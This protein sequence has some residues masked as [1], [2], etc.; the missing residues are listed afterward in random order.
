L[1]I[2][3]P[4]TEAVVALLQGRLAPPQAVSL[5]MGRQSRAESH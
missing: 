3:M 2:E 4:I 1:G 5:L